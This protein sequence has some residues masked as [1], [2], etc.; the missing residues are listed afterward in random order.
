[1][2]TVLRHEGYSFSF[3]KGDHEPP[4]VHVR[5]AG[6]VAIVDIGNGSGEAH[7]RLHE[8]LK[9]H[10][11]RRAVELVEDHRPQLLDAWRQHN[12]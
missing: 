7:L 2:P 1:M 4:H 3:H 8:G 5:R 9:R 12:E 10:E 11:I 6:G